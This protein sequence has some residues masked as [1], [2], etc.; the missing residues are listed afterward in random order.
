MTSLAGTGRRGSALARDPVEVRTTQL[1]REPAVRAWRELGAGPCPD[2]LELLRR[3]H[4]SVVYRLPGVGRDGSDVIAKQCLWQIA[5]DERAVY[6]LLRELP[7]AHLVYYGFCAEPAREFGWLFIEDARGDPWDPGDT[8]QRGMAARWLAGLHTASSGMTSATRL[9][10]RGPAWFRSHLHNAARWIAAGFTNPVL[11]PEA[12]PILD[13]VLRLLDAVEACWPEVEIAC[14]AMPRALVHGDFAERNVRIRCDDGEPR[15]LAFDWEVAGWGLPA[16][17][18]PN[19]DISAYAE[20][21]HTDWPS[22]DLAAL[23]RLAQLGQLLR[24]GIAAVSWASESLATA[25]P[26]GA[27]RNFVLYRRRIIDSLAALGWR[28]DWGRP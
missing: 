17:D 18:L 5:L 28:A 20:A 8:E 13:G 6:E 9:P 1:E 24:G 11:A 10:D 22:L 19:I 16:V 3:R 25:W 15:V 12:R 7:G 21:V 23:E 14:A 4:K 27:I 26:E 2:R